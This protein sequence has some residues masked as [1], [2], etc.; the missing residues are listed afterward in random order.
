ML[1]INDRIGKWTVIGYSHKVNRK[2]GKKWKV[3]HFWICRCECGTE[4]V[5]N[6]KNL[7]SGKSTSCGC[8]RKKE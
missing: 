4:R 5:V 8:S 7:A 1:N 6:G 2:S 3:D